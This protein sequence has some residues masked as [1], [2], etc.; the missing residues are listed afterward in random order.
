M[1]LV[2]FGMPEKE[3]LFL[4][5]LMNLNVFFEGGAFRGETASRASFLFDK[6]ITV[7]KSEEMY[8]VAKNN[9]SEIKNIDLFLGDTRDYLKVIGNKYDNIL[10]WLDAHWSGGVTYGKQDECPLIEELSIIFTNERNYV[11]L[12]DDA[13][14]FITPPPRPHDFSEW[15]SLKDISDVIPVGWDLLI[16]EDVI[17]I[18]PI[19]YENEFKYLIQNYISVNS[20]H[21]SK[22]SIIVNSFKRRKP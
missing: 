17:Y 9:I 2:R 3:V 6:V 19:K 1:G 4:K 7:E 18:F 8:S 11:I 12:I 15:P 13:R 22:L 16:Y 5:K 14:L 21:K 10:Y 20:E